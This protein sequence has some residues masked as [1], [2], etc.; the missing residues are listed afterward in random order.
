MGAASVDMVDGSLMLIH[1]A[2]TAVMEWQ[3]A[4]K[5]ELDQIIEKYQKEREDLDTIDKVIASLYARKSGKTVE[6]CLTKM[7]RAAWLSPQDALEFGLIDAIRDDEND[8]KKAKNIRNHFVNKYSKEF[9][10]PPVP[11]NEDKAAPTKSLLGKTAEMMKSLFR[12]NPAQNQEEKPMKKIFLNVMALL[13]ITDGFKLN[14][15]ESLTLSK[16]QMKTIDEALGNHT[17]AIDAA[18][19]AKDDL[20]TKLDKALEDLKKMTDDLA[21]ANE[22]IENLKKVPGDQTSQVTDDKIDEEEDFLTSARDSFNR[23]KDI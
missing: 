19:K 11:A 8:G 16:E 13:A 15:D 3:S 2:S 4:N 14:D 17:A 22:T 6:E 7:D 18:N 1:N 9:G 20:Q 5:K 23:I 21:T 12:N 10:L